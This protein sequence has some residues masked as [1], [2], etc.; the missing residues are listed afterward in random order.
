MGRPTKPTHRTKPDDG[1]PPPIDVEGER[2]ETL[3][4]GGKATAEQIAAWQKQAEE[5]R[6]DPRLKQ[7]FAVDFANIVL[8]RLDD[9][10][11]KTDSPK[12]V[13]NCA[14]VGRDYVEFAFRKAKE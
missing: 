14:R 2:G 4:L 9:I 6:R 12:T 13:E 10:V 7:T 3:G 8:I 1:L 11:R 5:W